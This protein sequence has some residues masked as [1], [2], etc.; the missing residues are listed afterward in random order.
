[1]VRWKKA[2]CHNKLDTILRDLNTEKVGK[3][4][5]ETGQERDTQWHNSE[6]QRQAILS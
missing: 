2:T 3:L 5:Q 4:V 1:M 6:F